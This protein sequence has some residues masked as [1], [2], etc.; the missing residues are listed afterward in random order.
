[1]VDQA[2]FTRFVTVPIAQQ[3]WPVRGVWFIFVGWW[4]SAIVMT[5]SWVLSS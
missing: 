5:I 4:A 2:G 1:M 3:P